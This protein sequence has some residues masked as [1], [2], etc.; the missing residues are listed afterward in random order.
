M[1]ILV[2]HLNDNVCPL[3]GKSFLEFGS[4]LFA[5]LTVDKHL[6]S[7]ELGTPTKFSSLEKILF[8]LGHHSASTGNPK[9]IVRQRLFSE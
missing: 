4:T 6:A 3:F 8:Y 2:K 9:T 1:L 5:T 7:W